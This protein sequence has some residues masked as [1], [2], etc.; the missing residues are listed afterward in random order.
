MQFG[1]VRN[2]GSNNANIVSTLDN[3]ILQKD[4]LPQDPP[5]RVSLHN[6]AAKIS[7]FL[8]ERPIRIETRP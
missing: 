1:S 2:N 4:L 3:K 7:H 8:S 5:T 6:K